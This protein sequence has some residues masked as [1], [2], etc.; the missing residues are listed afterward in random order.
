MRQIIRNIKPEDETSNLFKEFF[1]SEKAGGLILIFCTVLSIILANS[2]F[3]DTYTNF[4]NY[5]LG[6]HTIQ[7]WINDGLMAIFFLLI[8][9]ELERE[10]YVGELS[11]LKKT[12]LPVS[13]AIG[14]MLI[15]ALVYLLF[16][17][18]TSM[19]SGF[20]IPMATDIAF[21][22]G[23]LSMIKNVPISLK[24]FLTG[25]AIVD[26]LGAI[27]II[28]IF[29]SKAIIPVNLIIS[30]LLFVVLLILNRARV[31]NLIPYVIGGI[32][33]WYF[34]SL[35][36][37]HATISGVLLAFA[38]P[39][40][41]GDRESPSDRLQHWLHKPVAFFILPL[42]ALA[43]TA[44]VISTGLAGLFSQNYAAGILA[45]LVI[46][47]PVGILLFGFLAVK[48][49]ICSLPDLIQWK[50]ITGI[51]FIAGIGFTMSVFITLLAFNDLAV[52]NNSKI[53]IL[54]GSLI[55]GV[56]G[57][58]ILNWS[59]RNSKPNRN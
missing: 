31:N 47:K 56:A 25:L 34:M 21:A 55:S 16:N 35:S 45:G 4:W 3:R 40:R 54:L 6:S 28:A 52:I 11:T 46:G 43:N 24:V 10:I 23:I 14:G 26:D 38:I 15:P 48:M 9:L 49:K 50:H 58:L 2:G 44:T 30:L 36:G 20:G 7:H 59:L 33:M 8:G 41:K 5:E 27:T 57:Y 29:Y 19:Q 12:L 53:S 32:G 17:S 39:F 22:V 1:D 37:V 13:S 42:F 51:G 18:G